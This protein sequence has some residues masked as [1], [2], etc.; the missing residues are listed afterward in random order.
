MAG[1][2]RVGA[3]AECAVTSGK[4]IRE[5]RRGEDSEAVSDELAVIF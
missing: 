2:S 4:I 5:E 3:V 1:R